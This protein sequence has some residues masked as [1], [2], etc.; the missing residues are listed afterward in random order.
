[1]PLSLSASD[2][3]RVRRLERVT[4]VL[5]GN[6]RFGSSKVRNPASTQIDLA[7]YVNGDYITQAQPLDMTAN[8]SIGLSQRN[9]TRTRINCITLPVRKVPSI[10]I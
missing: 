1:M 2:M 7:A 4:K 10:Q 9:F 6:S 5:P 3:T 8:I